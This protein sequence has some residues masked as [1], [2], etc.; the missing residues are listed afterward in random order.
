MIAGLAAG[1][2]LAATAEWP[3]HAWPFWIA[4]ALLVQFRLLCNLFDGMVAVGAGRSSPVGELYNEVPDRISDAAALIGLGY[5]AGG[6]PWLGFTAAVLAVFTAYVR[7]LG[8]AAGAGSHFIGP[9]AKPQRMFLVTIT[10]LYVGLAPSTWE[11]QVAGL[12][13]PALTLALVAAGCGATSVRR[14]QR[15]ARRL[16]QDS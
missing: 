6:A 11:P 4:S 9:M 10:A 2:S 1:A 5:A 15:I 13:L 3:A 8:V 12:D 16:R 7:A 14:L